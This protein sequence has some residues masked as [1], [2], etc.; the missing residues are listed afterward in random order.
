M[1]NSKLVPLKA[2]KVLPFGRNKDFVGRQSQL[3]RLIEIL[4][5]K[6][7]EEDCQRAALVGLGGVGKPKLP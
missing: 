1:A 2:L 4:H 6:D 7:T 5:T 3:D